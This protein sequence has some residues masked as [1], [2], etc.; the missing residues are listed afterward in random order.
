MIDHF[1]MFVKRQGVIYPN[2]RQMEL[3]IRDMLN[4]YEE[5]TK[6]GRKVWRHAPSQPDDCLHAQIFGWMAAK[7]VTLDPLFTYN[8]LPGS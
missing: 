8:G 7:F 6:F 1:F 5:V 3:P 2:V 4:E